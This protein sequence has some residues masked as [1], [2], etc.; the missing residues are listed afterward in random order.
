MANVNTNTCQPATNTTNRLLLTIIVLFL[1]NFFLTFQASG[2][3]IP[4]LVELFT[5]EGC[6]S[7]PAADSLLTRIEKEQP[8]AGVQVIALGLHVDYWNYLGWKDKFSSRAFTRRQDHYARSIGYGRTYT[9]QIVV[10]GRY[11]FVG[12]NVNLAYENIKKAAVHTKAALDIQAR[13]IDGEQIELKVT[14]PQNLSNPHNNDRQIWLAIRE[15]N[16][17]NHIKAGEND[18][19][20]LKHSAVL[21]KLILLARLRSNLTTPHS[22][23]QV[24]KLSDQW[25][26]K[27]ISVI[28]MVQDWESGPGEILA[29]ALLRQLP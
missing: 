19:E 22:W 9:P 10:D 15:D 26:K 29:A 5:S 3:D 4:V 2:A 23:T 25:N 11:Q 24:V 18:G 16:L 17:A 20:Y 14:L 13:Q 21:R 7:C 6:S 8:I 12:S 1:F 27:N 28:A